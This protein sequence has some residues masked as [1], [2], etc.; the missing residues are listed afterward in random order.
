MISNT[1]ELLT[2]TRDKINS[3]LLSVNAKRDFWLAE[4]NLAP[5]IYGGFSSASGNSDVAATSEGSG[6]G[7]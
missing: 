5:A 2:D 4:A 3:I 1:F 7:H 6:S